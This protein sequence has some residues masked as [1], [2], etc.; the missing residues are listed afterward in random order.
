MNW[1]G[2]RFVTTS[3]KN[4]G[5]NDE[6]IV[7]EPSPNTLNGNEI[8]LG[9][10]PKVSFCIPTYNNERTLDRCLES[11]IN[12]EYP[13]IEIIIV[14]GHSKDKTIEIASRYTDKIY[15]EDG[16]LGSA[17][18]T[19]IEHATA[20]VLA[21]FDSDIYIPHNR[22]LINA[23]KYFN[24]C[25]RVSTVW[26]VNV[27]PPNASLITRLYFN[28]W[29]VVEEDRIKNYRGLF[30]GGCA[31][32]LKKCFEEIGG[33]DRSIHWGEDYYWM[34]KFRDRGYKVVFIE[35]P[36]YHDTMRSLKE[37]TKKQLMGANTFTKSGFGFMGL[38]TV[39]VF[40]EN[41]ILGFKCMIN[42]LIKDKDSSWLLYPLFVGI[43]VFSYVYTYL[44]PSKN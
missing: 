32:F 5:E 33:I 29:R 44:R 23:I 36:L 43:R 18:Q 16:T 27:A 8:N 19:S 17:R 41:A 9:N 22:W 34:G 10:L 38:S 37:F 24:Y 31:L 15:F 6:Y 12:Q 14:D 35:D 28:Y 7:M 11:I 26:P 20:P 42:G 4:R 1:F 39:D 21:I 2:N 30:G 3:T 40:Y 13:N 25:D